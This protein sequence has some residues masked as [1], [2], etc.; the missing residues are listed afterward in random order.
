MEQGENEGCCT[1]DRALFELVMVGRIDESEALRAADSPNNLRLQIEKLR[2]SGGGP[3][4]DEPVLRLVP[5]P[6]KL[7]AV[8]R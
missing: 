3:A 2:R 8:R 1:F 5:A 4:A 7:A 6:P